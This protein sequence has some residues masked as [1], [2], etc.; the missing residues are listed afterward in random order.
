MYKAL[1]QNRRFCRVM[2]GGFKTHYQKLNSKS[3]KII[4]SFRLL[5]FF[6]YFCIM[7][8]FNRLVPCGEKRSIPTFWIQ[9]RAKITKLHRGLTQYAHA[10]QAEPAPVMEQAPMT[11]QSEFRRPF[12]LSAANFFSALRS[13]RDHRKSF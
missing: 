2:G 1:M 10:A 6:T 5:L 3:L 4:N 13:D 8:T 9:R 11:P 7:R 12:E